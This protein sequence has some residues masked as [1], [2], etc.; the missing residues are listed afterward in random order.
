MHNRFF[1]FLVFTGFLALLLSLSCGNSS[2]HKGN[3]TLKGKF[4]NSNGD[5]V[6]FVN[7]SSKDFVTLDST[8]TDQ[9]GA[10]E[11]HGNA[12]AKG[13]FNVVVGRSSKQFATVIMAPGETVTLTGDAK[14][15]GYTWKAE[16][17]ID[18]DHFE[19]LNAYIAGYQKRREVIIQQ[20]DS[21]QRIFQFQASV[22]NN[23]KSKLDSLD[24]VFQKPFDSLQIIMEK[25]M[26]EGAD[27]V[28][29][30]IDKHP[31]SFANIAAL[32]ML[33]QDKDIAYFEKTTAALEAKYAGAPNVKMLRSFL[34]ELKKDK[35]P[36]PSKF[37]L[38]QAPE[39][40]ILPDPNG[41]TRKLSDLKGKIVLLDFWASWC[42]P[43]REEL[44]NVVAA[45]KKYHDKGFEVFSISLDHDQKAWTNA[46]ESDGL[47]WPWHVL[48]AQDQSQS[49]AIKY[50]ATSIP[51][52]F[53][54]NREGKLVNLDLRGSDLEK[55]LAEQFEK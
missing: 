12:V 43:C 47:I 23:N 55:A 48:D 34:D 33:D 42:K 17:S 52:A 45:Y 10:F 40:I 36:R 7:V 6:F 2:A 54:L 22:S 14:N 41:K 32:R 24:R 53:L 30:F 26:D 9:D 38:G 5:T 27:Y 35:L 51:R 3:L 28:R 44:P 37:Q 4:S 49:Y 13:F 8:I 25:M 46:I 15:L 50:G 19:E 29:H 39:D 1:A 16:G 21:M 11:L 18:T 31:D 20:L